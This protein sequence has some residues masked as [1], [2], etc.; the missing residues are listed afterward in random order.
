MYLCGCKCHK[1]F[2]LKRT[3]IVSSKILT[4]AQKDKS[5]LTK[6]QRQCTFAPHPK[7]VVWDIGVVHASGIVLVHARYF[8]PEVIFSD[9]A[10]RTYMQLDFTIAGR[11][12]F[13]MHPTYACVDYIS[14]HTP[15]SRGLVSKAP[16]ECYSPMHSSPAN[17]DRHGGIC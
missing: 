15:R 2:G 7:L 1:Q 17:H 6:H 10:R 9:G 12:V 11:R 3:K 8:Q 5:M 13:Q 4:H 16:A 14:Q